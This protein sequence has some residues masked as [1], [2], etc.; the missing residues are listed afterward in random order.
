MGRCVVRVYTVHSKLLHPAP[1]TTS[2]QLFCDVFPFV[3]LFSAYCLVFAELWTHHHPHP[4]YLGGNQGGDWETS[5]DREEEEEG[6]GAGEEGA[7]GAQGTQ[8]EQADQGD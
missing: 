6:G 8:G 1:L 4:Y 3:Y 2:S 5:E 7:G